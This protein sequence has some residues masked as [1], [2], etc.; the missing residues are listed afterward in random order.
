MGAH[1][2]EIEEM[3]TLQIKVE[4]KDA[5]GEYILR[6]SIGEGRYAGADFTLANSI[7]GG[8][9]VIE[10]NG[11]TWTVSSRDIVQALID[12]MSDARAEFG[13]KRDDLV[14]YLVDENFQVK[15]LEALIQIASLF[16]YC[17]ESERVVFEF[18]DRLKEELFTE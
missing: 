8:S 3:R 6:K 17:E 9:L 14:S 1:K 15:H 11:K 13:D 10:V 5:T 12:K 4:A 18:A 16:N 2:R 7:P